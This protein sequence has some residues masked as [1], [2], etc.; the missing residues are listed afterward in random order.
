M[1]KKKTML[2]VYILAFL[3]PFLIMGFWFVKLGIYPFGNR[4]VLIVD[5]WHE[6]YPFLA[7]LY[8]KL[9]SGESLLYSWRIGVGSDFV[10]VIAYVL[11]SPFN[12]LAVLFPESW[13]REMF[14][15]TVLIKV[16]FA[17]SFSAFVLCK[18]KEYGREN[19]GETE[20]KADVFGTL[21]FSTFYALCGWVQGYYS[22]SMFLDSFAIFPLVVLGICRLVREKKCRLYTISL[23]AVILMNYYIGLMVCIFT[24]LFFFAQCIVHWRGWEELWENLKSIILYSALALMIS[25]VFIVP[26][27]VTLQNA[28][29]RAGFP[30][31]LVI[32]QGWI[33][34]IS[35]IFAFLEYTALNVNG[36]PYIYC[37]VLCL[38]FLFAY[39]RLPG[40]TR[41]EKAVYLGLLLFLLVSMNINVLDY[42]WHGLRFTHDIPYRFSFMFSFLVVLM[43]YNAYTDV[44]MLQKKDC[45]LI[46]AAGLSCYFLVAADRICRYGKEYGCNSVLEVINAGGSSFREFLWKNL[47]IMAAYL[48]IIALMVKKKLKKTK[49]MLLLMYVAGLELIS[50]VT[51]KNNAEWS[52]DRDSYPDRYEA[53]QEVLAD[54]K[55]KEKE[56]SFYRTEFTKWRILNPGTVYDYRGV[57][58]FSSTTNAGVA[59]VFGNIGLPGWDN[60][61][62][63]QNTTPVNNLFLNLKYLMEKEEP[64]IVNAEY[65]TKTAQSG[66]VRVYRNEAYL[67]IGFMVESGMADFTFEGNTPFEKQN[68]LLKAASGVEG[69]VFEALDIIHVGHENVDVSRVEY[70]FYYYE[71][72]E[73]A[74]ETV[75]KGKKQEK[76]PENEKFKFN[77]EMPKDGSAYAFM[78]LK[79]DKRADNT[80]RVEFDDEVKSYAIYRDGN[81]FPAGTYKAGDLFSVRAET[82]AGRVDNMRIYVSILNED[83]FDEAYELLRDE[84]LEVTEWKDGYLKGDI[85][86]KKENLLY[87][88]IPY[89]TGWKV[90]VDGERAE[91]TPIFDAFI[92]V[93]LPEGKHTV[94]FRYSPVQAY[95]GIAVTLM[96]IGSF[97]LIM[98]MEKR[99]GRTGRAVS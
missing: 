21:L 70:G 57:T 20:K 55:E 25:A 7:E 93:M 30:D 92:G 43:A 95:L 47:I 98:A 8:R 5:A 4:Q 14:A 16:G 45:F 81:I 18:M 13:L 2:P 10:S 84:T 48:V 53:V 9:K 49:F 34:A 50:T 73:G 40:V 88:S 3:V 78:D 83:V 39:F 80:V 60:G 12:L 63:Y 86:V 67:P 62:Y 11:A 74:K 35:G 31:K 26:S 65:L 89:E 27:F 37:G 54:I 24:V 72:L 58:L 79:K 75:K 69:D 90:Y 33:T 77:Y 68:H 46:G 94:E 99:G 87:T 32:L 76:E 44:D 91:I 96:G 36:V 82:D 59:E 17:G 97:L 19:S 85:T 1:K 22:N 42:L 51:I 56:N 23:A 41:R 52:T 71:P 6:Y 66:D 15:L 28:C 61:Y 38:I 29:E 64:G